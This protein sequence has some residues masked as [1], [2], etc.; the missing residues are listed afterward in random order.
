MAAACWWSP[1][2]T[3]VGGG[4]VSLWSSGGSSVADTACRT[5]M[6]QLT[7]LMPRVGAMVAVLGRAEVTVRLVLAIFSA[8]S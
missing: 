1:C 7:G 6:L 5:G 3:A 2:S 8:G 4:G